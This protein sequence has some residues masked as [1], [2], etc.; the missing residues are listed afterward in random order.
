[1]SQFQQNRFFRSNEGRLYKQI[2][3]REEGEEIRQIFGVKKRKMQ[4]GY[5]K[6]RK[7]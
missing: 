6:L 5:K 7:I 3:G 4:L 1:M 2:D